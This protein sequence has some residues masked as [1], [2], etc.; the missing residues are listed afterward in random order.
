MVASR[1]VGAHRLTLAML[2]VTTIIRTPAA[3]SDL[4]DTHTCGRVI[5]PWAVEAVRDDAAHSDS[6][7]P[8]AAARQRERAAHPWDRVTG[9]AQLAA[10]AELSV[11]ADSPRSAMI[12]DVTL[13][14][15]GNGGT[16][17]AIDTH[18]GGTAITRGL[19]THILARA[20][21]RTRW[22]QAARVTAGAN[23]V[24]GALRDT[25][26]VCVR[27]AA[28]SRWLT[29]ARVTDAPTARS[30]LIIGEATQAR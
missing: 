30:A 17:H 20:E 18:L 2:V 4:R 15:G 11:L 3:I 5:L 13:A 14:S 21:P 28:R 8:I 29:K 19:A 26:A 23:E 9:G 16:A 1:A 22:H 6:A 10:C 7:V 25:C 27:I 12:V 24:P